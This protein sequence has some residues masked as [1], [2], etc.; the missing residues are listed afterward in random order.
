M[1]LTS[2]LVAQIFGTRY[3]STLY[4]VVFLSHQLGSFLGAWLGG[5]AYDVFGSYDIVWMTSIALGL[6]ATLLHWPIAD[7]PVQRLAGTKV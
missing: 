1:P 7:A 4:G 2:G 3:L 5:Y 6:A